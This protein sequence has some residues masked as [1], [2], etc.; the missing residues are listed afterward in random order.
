[1]GLSGPFLMVYLR[2]IGAVVRAA[3]TSD[4]L[5]PIAL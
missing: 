3:N 4:F 1:M 2:H 5:L